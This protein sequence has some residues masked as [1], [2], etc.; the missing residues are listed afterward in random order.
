MQVYRCASLDLYR[1]AGVQVTRFTLVQ[2]F[3]FTGVQFYNCTDVKVYRC[4]DVQLYRYAGV[5]VCKFRFVQVCRFTFVQVYRCAGVSGLFA[6]ADRTQ[7]TQTHKPDPHAQHG[8]T[9]ATTVGRCAGVTVPLLSTARTPTHSPFYS[10]YPIAQVRLAQCMLCFCCMPSD[11]QG[12][13]PHLVSCTHNLELPV[14][15]ARLLA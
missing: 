15:S 11:A 13:V 9:V 1:C 12:N 6:V 5:Q 2:V 7:N 14:P 4:A 3:R 10:L 8:A